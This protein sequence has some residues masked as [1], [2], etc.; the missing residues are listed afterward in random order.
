[1]WFDR[2][3]E[4]AKIAMPLITVVVTMFFVPRL[5]EWWSIRK[6]RRCYR[7]L[8]SHFDR[9]CRSLGSRTGSYPTVREE[10]FDKDSDIEILINKDKTT[11]TSTDAQ[12]WQQT[13]A[14]KVRT[15]LNAARIKAG[16]ESGKFYYSQSFLNNK[17]G[18][19]LVVLTVN[20]NTADMQAFC[21]SEWVLPKTK[22]ISK[23]RRIK[24]KFFGYDRSD[25]SIMMV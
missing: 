10:Y 23:L 21:S 25:Y 3:L 17:N 12:G 6:V 7:S 13:H 2:I 20:G 14:C 15:A 18:R 16:L 8:L 19:L 24:I 5:L 4:V 22:A 11:P 9:F 1:M